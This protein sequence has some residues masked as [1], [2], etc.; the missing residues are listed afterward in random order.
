MAYDPEVPPSLVA[1]GIGG[2]EGLRW[3]ALMW[4]DPIADVLVPGYISN[5]EELGMRPGDGLIYK[6]TNRGE[7]DHYDLIVLSVDAAGAATVAFPE[8]P[9]EALPLEIVIDPEDA[10]T[11]AVFYKAG[12]MVRISMADFAET[13][14]PALASQAEAEAGTENTKFMTALRVFQGIAA[15]I[16]GRAA[17]TPPVDADGFVITDSAASGAPKQ[18]TW[19]NLKAAMFAAWGALLAAATD[20]AT[21]VDADVMTIADSAASN[22]TKKVTW[23]NVKATV[24]AALGTTIAALTGKATPVDA[25]TLALSDSAAS[26]AGKSLTWANLKATMFAA[27]GVLLAAAA[28]KTTPVGADGFL[29]YDSAASNAPKQLTFT[30]L[31]TALGITSG[32]RTFWARIGITGNVIAGR[33]VASATDDGGGLM[34]STLSV[35]YT[36]ASTFAAHGTAYD[37]SGAGQVRDV[38][39]TGRTASTIAWKCSNTAGALT[40]PVEW[41]ISG[42]G[43]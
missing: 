9:E 37:G 7:W 20:K 21:P 26:G 24:L 27:I 43:S 35:A 4:V 18:V 33:G 28:S 42:I 23:A 14:V 32:E 10:A 29:I 17:K 3:F 8:V 13:I 25:D 40:D 19:V 41:N 2:T 6:D 30:N 36:S 38:V 16:T 34:T 39:I 5:A 1:Q 12:R 11:Y 15:Y 31:L 22:A